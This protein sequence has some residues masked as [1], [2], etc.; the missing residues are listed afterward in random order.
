VNVFVPANVV[1]AAAVVLGTALDEPVVLQ[2][3]GRSVVLRCRRAGSGDTVVVKAYQVA[4]TSRKSFGREVAGLGFSAPT[5]IGPA[6]LAA[7][8]AFP[9]LVLEDLG[10]APS[11]ADL[12]LGPPSSGV[13]DVL[14]GWAATC[15][16][17]AAWSAGRAGEF[18]G[19]A[20]VLDPL[21]SASH[22]LGWADVAAPDGLSREVASVGEFLLSED[23]QVFSPGDLCPDNNLIVA[24]EVRLI[25]FE[26]A[27]FHSVFLDAAYFRMPFSTC[28][29]V[30]RLPGPLAGALEAT[31]RM[32]VCA[33]FPG[34]ADDVVWQAGVRRAMAFWTLH[35]MSYLLDRAVTE[36][37]SM[38]QDEPKAPTTRAILRHRWRTLRDSLVAGGEFPALA[39][40]MSRLLAA[41][42]QWQ[43]A[44]LDVYPALTGWR[45][46]R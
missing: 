33:A 44:P 13:A 7:D 14:S 11:L 20:E 36:N 9:L 27:G 41:T 10:S 46:A 28:W 39:E 31:Y 5:G 24:D 21:P 17:L 19:P 15:G 3:S 40:A 38:N 43:V 22:M 1:A 37:R 42:E 25:D 34:L 8:P 26:S 29:C 32:S 18:S 35:T 16:R 6:L 45:P 12:L 23:H 4:P 2:G 30:L